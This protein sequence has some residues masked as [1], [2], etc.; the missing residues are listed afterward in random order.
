M[1]LTV[2][3]HRKEMFAPVYRNAAG[4]DYIDTA[5][6]SFTRNVCFIFLLNHIR[7]IKSNIYS[8]TQLNTSH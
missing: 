1:D 6:A 8:Y 2:T 5:D 7:H 3:I 4:N